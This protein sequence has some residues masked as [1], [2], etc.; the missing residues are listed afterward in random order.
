MNVSQSARK[1]IQTEWFK[2]TLTKGCQKCLGQICMT[3][4]VQHDSTLRYFNGKSLPLKR[5]HRCCLYI[6]NMLRFLIPLK[7]GYQALMFQ[8]WIRYCEFCH[9]GCHTHQILKPFTILHA[10]IDR[11][12]Q[13]H[14]E[15]IR[16]GCEEHNQGL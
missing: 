9:H 10:L 6:G 15:Q 14:Q 11:T 16:S 7:T 13:Q 1:M 4:L 5:P 2:S 3:I 8:D 12:I